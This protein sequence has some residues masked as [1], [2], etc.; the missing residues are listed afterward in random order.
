[1]AADDV[2][3]KR[4]SPRR[5]KQASPSLPPIPDSDLARLLAGEHAGPHSF[6][7]AHPASLGSREG[8]LVRALVPSAERSE[9]VLADGQV[10]PMEREASGLSD[11]YRSFIPDASFP[12]DYRF[13]FHYADGAV[14]DRGDP[15]R[16]LPTVG[17]VDLHLFNEGMHRSLWK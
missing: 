10:L 9:L 4:R 1:M 6:L 14:W 13:R 12:L 5:T 16:F 17:D 7:G 15:Y 2:A 8:I 11:L 3:Q